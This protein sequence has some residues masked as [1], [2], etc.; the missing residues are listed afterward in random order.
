MRHRR[1]IQRGPFQGL[2]FSLV[3]IGFLC[4]MAEAFL[5]NLRGQA[6]AEFLKKIIK[7]LFQGPTHFRV[8]S[9]KFGSVL[10]LKTN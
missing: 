8:S 7:G 2:A 1:H 10:N 6:G 5:A 4:P 9:A 3:A